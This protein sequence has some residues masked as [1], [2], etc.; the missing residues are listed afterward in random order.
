M[1]AGRSGKG[2]SRLGALV[3]LV[4]LLAGCD[5]KPRQEAWCE[6]RAGSLPKECKAGDLLRPSSAAEIMERCQLPIA[7]GDI[8]AGVCRYLG[9][10]RVH[11]QPPP[12]VPRSP[13]Q[14]AEDARRVK[15]FEA[16]IQAAKE[17]QQEEQAARD[18]SWAV[19]RM[20]RKVLIKE[21]EEQ[22]PRR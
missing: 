2:M 18:A 9:Y 21:L 13:L 3:V 7:P 17:A 12:P 4:L 5:Q 14:E 1:G 11:R 20:R 15:E 6:A 8:E 16:E 19:D 22:S 10:T